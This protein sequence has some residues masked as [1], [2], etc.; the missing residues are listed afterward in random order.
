LR[1]TTLTTLLLSTAALALAS[2]CGGAPASA[3]AQQ[4][5]ALTGVAAAGTTVYVANCGSCHGND[6]KGTP[7]S[8]NVS[9]AA[10]VKT[11]TPGEFIDFILLGVPGT[12]MLGFGGAGGLTDQQL[13]DV[14]AYIDTVLAP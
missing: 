13:A 11:R 3:R 6:G 4:I 1:P 2:S 7:S 5:L 10:R 9:I 8:D 12:G 14:Y